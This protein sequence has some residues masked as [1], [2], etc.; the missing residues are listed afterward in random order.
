MVLPMK[1]FSHGNSKS[2]PWPKNT[3]FTSR[4]LSSSAAP[5]LTKP[6]APQL[7]RPIVI[8]LAKGMAKL[9]I[10]KC[11]VVGFSYGGMVAFKLA[12]LYPG[13]VRAIVV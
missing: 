7:F 1:A 9:G 6:I 11:V 2:V 8:G 4:T 5:R 12:E 10:D 3:L 13:L